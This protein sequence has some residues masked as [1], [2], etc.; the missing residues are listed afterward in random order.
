MIYTSLAIVARA[1]AI[2]PTCKTDCVCVC[3]IVNILNTKFPRPGWANI[4]W[5]TQSPPSTLPARRYVCVCARPSQIRINQTQCSLGRRN[6]RVGCAADFGQDSNHLP[7]FL[8]QIIPDWGISFS[9][10][11]FFAILNSLY[12]SRSQRNSATR[13]LSM[14]IP[15]K[16]L[17]LKQLQEVSFE[18]SMMNID[19]T[20]SNCN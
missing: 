1:I 20:N 4:T 2:E 6:D 11:T 12:L 13:N 16:D 19:A 7:R 14:H 3:A 8:C 9:R 5:R 18:G 17:S 10:A 15:V